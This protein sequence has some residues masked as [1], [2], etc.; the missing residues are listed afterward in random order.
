MNKKLL[1]TL[2]LAGTTT[3]LFGA[4]VPDDSL[5]NYI[6]FSI[7]NIERKITNLKSDDLKRSFVQQVDECLKADLTV[8]EI[9]DFSATQP[10]G[11]LGVTAIQLK[12]F[13]LKLQ[14]ERLEAVFNNL[15]KL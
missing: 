9:A 11:I 14:S 15:N 6:M 10:N 4:D 8:E 5:R 12:N 7:N 2:L 1:I 13:N 3:V